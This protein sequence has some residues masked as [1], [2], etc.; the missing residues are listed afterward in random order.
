MFVKSPTYMSKNKTSQFYT[1]RGSSTDFKEN[2]PTD[3]WAEKKIFTV[4]AD[5]KKDGGS[6]TDRLTDIVIIITNYTAQI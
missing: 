6:T 2:I 3:F 5:S 4:Y 1:L